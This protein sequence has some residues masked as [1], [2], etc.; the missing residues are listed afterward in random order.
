MKRNIAYLLIALSVSSLFSI[1]IPTNSS[2]T[3]SAEISSNGRILSSPT[4]TS[5]YWVGKNWTI[6]DGTW[7]IANNKLYGSGSAEALITTFDNVQSDYS[8]TMD[9]TIDTGTESS[10]VIRYID[11]NNYYWMG[12]GCWG[13]LFSI[14]RMLNGFPTE[15]KGSG[16]ASN[17]QQDATYTLKALASANTLQL[18]VNETQVLQITDST[19][20]YGAFG[21]RTYSS[22]IQAFNISTTSAPAP[23]PAP[24]PGPNTS[25]FTVKAAQ[26][27]LSDIKVGS[28]SYIANWKNLLQGMGLNTVRLGSGIFGD[29]WGINMVDNPT[30]WAQHLEDCLTTLTG[31]DRFGN[32]VSTGINKVWWQG[33]GAPWGT[34]FGIYSGQGKNDGTNDCFPQLVSLNNQGA[35]WYFDPYVNGQGT[36]TWRFNLVSSYEKANGYP[37]TKAYLDKLAGNNALE[38]NFLADSRIFAWSPSNECGMGYGASDTYHWVIADMDYIKTKGGKTIADA[39]LYTYSPEWYDGFQEVAPL[40]AGHADYIEKHDYRVNPLLGHA[41]DSGRSPSYAWDVWRNDLQAFLTQEM[42]YANLNGFDENHVIMGEFGIWVGYSSSMGFTYDVSDGN[43]ADYVSNYYQALEGAGFKIA[44][45]YTANG[46]PINTPVSFG[47][48]IPKGD[49]TAI[50]H[51]GYDEIAAAYG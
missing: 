24:A 8:V 6:V 48:I 11:A 12:I 25:S 30:T 32:G 7:N 18:H 4:Q 36:N 19:F 1:A 26:I 23:Q 42:Y 10:I 50:I 40:F 14:G 37:T 35:G 28:P 33:M 9:A 20:A 13:H 22:S 45:Y 21:I 46:Y 51:G 5:F 49:G 31:K 27:W 38:H 16:L 34:E 29:T 17:V 44:S 39:P 3:V 43:S 41:F 2:V 15:I 47:I